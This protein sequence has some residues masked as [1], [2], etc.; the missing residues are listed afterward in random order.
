[1]HTKIIHDKQICNKTIKNI[2]LIFVKFGWVINYILN[3]CTAK[4]SVN[5]WLENSFIIKS[6][7]YI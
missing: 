5:H 7:T 2:I 3:T 4:S 6:T 1:M